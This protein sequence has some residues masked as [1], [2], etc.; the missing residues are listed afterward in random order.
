[1]YPNRGYLASYEEYYDKEPLTPI[2]R[3]ASYSMHLKQPCF[4]SWLWGL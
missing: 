2:T 3:R 1:M 4:L